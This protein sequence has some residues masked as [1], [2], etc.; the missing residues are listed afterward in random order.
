MHPFWNSVIKV[1]WFSHMFT[2]ILVIHFLIQICPM[3]VAP[4]LLTFVGFLFT[5]ANW[6]ILAYYD[7]YYY[8]SSVITPEYPP[9]PRWIW[10]VC[11]INHF[12]AHTLGIINLWMFSSTIITA[13]FTRWY[14]WKT[15]SKNKQQHPVGWAV[16]PWVRFVD[17]T[18]HPNGLVLSVWSCRAYNISYTSLFLSA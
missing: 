1:T 17:L 15:S 5:F 9:I 14:W 2:F 7:Y 8:A 16:W 6:V 18:L 3:W 12:L 4:N 11:A 10:L 13:L